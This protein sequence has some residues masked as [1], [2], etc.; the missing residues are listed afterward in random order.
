MTRTAIAAQLVHGVLCALAGALLLYI[1]WTPAAPRAEFSVVRVTAREFSKIEPPTKASAIAR[2]VRPVAKLEE[3]VV[4]DSAGR[5]D[6]ESFI[7]AATQDSAASDNSTSLPEQRPRLALAYGGEITR[8]RMQLFTLTTSGDKERLTYNACGRVTWR[9][10][11]D[12]A[13]VQGS[14]FCWLTDAL[15]MGGAGVLGFGIAER[16]P[17]AIAGGVLMLGA[18]E[19]LRRRSP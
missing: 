10:V 13:F 19:L 18:R 17:Y 15:E 2:V 5:E 11:G 3:R 7:A 12:S 8:S 4:A 14:R 1:V 9:M 16:D 6:L